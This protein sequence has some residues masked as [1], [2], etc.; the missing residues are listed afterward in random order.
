MGEVNVRLIGRFERRVLV[1]WIF[2]RNFPY[3]LFFLGFLL[4]GIC[5]WVWR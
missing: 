5:G 1:G 3:E 4:G 2:F